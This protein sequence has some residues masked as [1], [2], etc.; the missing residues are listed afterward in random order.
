MKFW[1]ID[2]SNRRDESISR[3]LTKKLVSKL[4]EE[5]KGAEVVYRDVGESIPLL[6]ETMI[7][8]YYT[9]Q[10]A[11]TQEQ[12]SSIE[13]SNQIVEE[14]KESDVWVIGAPIYNFAAPGSLKAW[15]DQL[16][17]V[18]ETFKY[19]EDGPVGLLQNKKVFVIITSGG[20]KINS[21]ID[22]LTPWI[23]QFLKFVGVKDV[24]IVEADQLMFD[25]NKVTKAEATIEEVASI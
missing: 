25:Q 14:A 11:R 20:T 9:P 21:E 3:K 16:A 1:H 12:L 5:N 15:A 18:G 4:L 23:K 2:S 22:F 19:T 7:G 17:R 8:S 13:V 10:K 24:T 6:T